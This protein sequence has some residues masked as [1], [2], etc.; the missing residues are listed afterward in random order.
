MIA[1]PEPTLGALCSL[2][3]ALA[4]AVVSL[5]VRRLLGTLNSPTINALRTL[6]AGALLMAWVLGTEGLQGLREI[7]LPTFTLLAASIV[8]SGSLGDTLFFESARFL[9]LARAM[10]ASMTYPMLSAVLAAILLDE[11]ITSALVMGSL[12]TLGGLALIVGARPS[13][14]DG[15]GHLWLGLL[16]SQGASV[17]WAV[18]VIML[19][20]PLATLDAT[21]AQAVR[22]PFAGLVLFATPWVWGSMGIVRRGGMALAGPIALLAVL[23]AGSSLFFVLG[24]KHAGVG[25]STV[26]SSTAPMFAIPLAT[27]FLR[28]RITRAAALGTLITVAGVAVLNL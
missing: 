2:A 28:E 18:G 16:A 19:K 1:L 5:C 25:V 21:A 26:L 6:G 20:V 15:P 10:T 23:T 13:E 27:L 7:G 8:V 14:P 3:S 17:A 24:V 4:W 11:P 9:G 12:L 22:L